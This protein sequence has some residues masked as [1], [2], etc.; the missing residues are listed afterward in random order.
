M[1]PIDFKIDDEQTI[2]NG[3]EVVRFLVNLAAYKNN[4]ELTA[5]AEKLSLF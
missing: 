5:N 4:K 2:V 1:R 3:N